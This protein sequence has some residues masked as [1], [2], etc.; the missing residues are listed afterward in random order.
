MF[1]RGGGNK[2]TIN[3]VDFSIFNNT[4]CLTHKNQKAFTPAN[5]LDYFNLTK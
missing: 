5:S 4:N 2:K 3:D 1:D